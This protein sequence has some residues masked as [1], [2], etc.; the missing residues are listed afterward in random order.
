VDLLDEHE[1]R[2]F[3]LFL[4]REQRLGGL[5]QQRVRP[6]GVE[7]AGDIKDDRHALCQ[8][9]LG[10]FA[11]VLGP[12]LEVALLVSADVEDFVVFFQPPVLAIYVNNQGTKT[13]V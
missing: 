13:T 9:Q 7:K 1:E 8:R 10:K 11:A 2:P 3:P 5:P 12:D 6:V 4:L